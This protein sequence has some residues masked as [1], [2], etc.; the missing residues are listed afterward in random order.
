MLFLCE[1]PLQHLP[2]F[3]SS[4]SLR[5]QG[6]STSG[7]PHVQTGFMFSAPYRWK[8][9]QKTLKSHISLEHYT[10]IFAF[11]CVIDFSNVTINRHV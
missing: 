10:Q 11:P 5:P 7:E 3:L 4:L 8:E 1:A 2:P 9:L 6:I